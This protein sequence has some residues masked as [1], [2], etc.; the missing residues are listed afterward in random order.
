MTKAKSFV[1]E[2][3]ATSEGISVCGLRYSSPTLQRLYEN[4]GEMSLRVM[5]EDPTDVRSILVFHP[6]RRIWMTVPIVKLDRL[7]F[8]SEIQ[9]L[10]RSFYA[11][12][13][14]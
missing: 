6:Q 1:I 3:K 14:Q 12:L 4:F 10:A 7:A 2:S 13:S 9:E 11:R 8:E 5:I